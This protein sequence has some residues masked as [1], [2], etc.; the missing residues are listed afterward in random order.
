MN[1]RQQHATAITSLDDVCRLAEIV[2]KSN[3][4]GV[5]SM[6]EAVVKIMTGIEMGFGPMAALA[7]CPIIDGKPC[8]GAH[9]QAAAVKRSGRY[10]Y[11][12]VRHTEEVC[13]LEFF[14]NG[15][16]VGTSTYTLTDAVA[17]GDVFASEGKGVKQADG[18]WWKKN[19]ACKKRNM[20]FARAMSN[21]YKWYA[22][23]AADGVLMYDP[24]ELEAPEPQPAAQL[25]HRP[26]NGQAAEQP[27]A[28]LT[29]VAAAPPVLITAPQQEDLNQLT[30][31]LGITEVQL[32]A[33]LKRDFPGT[34]GDWRQLTTAQASQ[35]IDRLRKKKAAGQ[36]GG[37]TPAAAG[38][39][40]AQQLMKAVRGG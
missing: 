38:S 14:E 28:V 40:S 27:A 3:L 16:S 4:Y 8:P 29:P 23:D 15:K 12:K 21:G 26:T 9:L 11:K 37:A 10:D 6:A 31:D 25:E 35:L 34:A 24:D 2:F 7:D 39:P 13:E 22:P 5:R 36:P 19:W 18:R 33:G 32:Q 30:I 1:E 20:L 17:G